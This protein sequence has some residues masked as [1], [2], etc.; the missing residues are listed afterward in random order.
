[1]CQVL[2]VKLFVVMGLTWSFGFLAT[3]TGWTAAI[4]LFTIFNS[5]QGAFIA[6]SFLITRQVHRLLHQ[7]V[8]G[9]VFVVSSLQTGV[10]HSTRVI[11][12][13]V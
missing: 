8:C 1:M 10:N 11:G 5:L 9:K 13:A 12:S 7:S 6:L 4:Y 3:M 2:Y